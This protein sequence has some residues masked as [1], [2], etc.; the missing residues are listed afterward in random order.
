MVT[1]YSYYEIL[2]PMDPLWDQS[3]A[4]WQN[5]NGQFEEIECA[6][7]TTYRKFIYKHGLNMHIY[8][9]S[10]GERYIYQFFY[11]SSLQIT[12]IAIEIQYNWFGKGFLPKVPE[13]YMK[14]WAKKIGIPFHRLEKE[15]NLRVLELQQNLN[16][17]VNPQ[18]DSQ[19]TPATHE[20]FP[21]YCAFCGEQLE[22]TNQ[23]CPHCGKL[24][25]ISE[26]S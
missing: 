20:G 1:R 16:R 23:F 9:T 4:F 3:M 18:F 22:Q 24:L 19:I 26:S 13:E 12:H 6:E 10:S 5:E 2:S 14:K 7:N 21:K 8:A 17:T 25:S 15:P 11:D